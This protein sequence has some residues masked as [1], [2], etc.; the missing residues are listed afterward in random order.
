MSHQR[1]YNGLI[2]TNHAL[3]RLTQRG[4]S[5]SL[6][7]SAF[8]TPDKTIPNRDGATEYQKRVENSL[9]TLIVKKNER[10]EWLVLSAWID[11]PLYGTHDWKKRENYRKY[12]KAGFWGK[13]WF[14][15]LRQL[16]F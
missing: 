10:N 8:H 9:I 13:I 7:S 6:A 2:W 12:Q 14:T 1:V 3:E 15:V 11:P 5:Q 16:G 4:L